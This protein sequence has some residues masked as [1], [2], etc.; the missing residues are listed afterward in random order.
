MPLNSNTNWYNGGALKDPYSTSTF[1]IDLLTYLAN[2]NHGSKEISN[3]VVVVS[4]RSLIW[5]NNRAKDLCTIPTFVHNINPSAKFVVLMK[6]P[7]INT[8]HNFIRHTNVK[9]ND[10]AVPSDMEWF[11][12]CITSQI[13][14]YSHCLSTRVSLGTCAYDIEMVNW[15]KLFGFCHFNIGASL[16]YVHILSVY[17]KDQF[18]FL[19]TE[20]LAKKPYDEVWKFLI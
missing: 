17:S 20:D 2:F 7:W 8:Y 15:D 13:M 4:S 18:L 3:L 10:D 14:W 16:Y 9:F 12:C 1:K 6:A 11:H 19:R 5:R